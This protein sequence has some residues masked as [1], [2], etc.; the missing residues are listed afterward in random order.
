MTYFPN[1]NVIQSPLQCNDAKRRQLFADHGP[2]YWADKGLYVSYDLLHLPPGF[3]TLS[4]T[5]V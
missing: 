1:T 2:I 4:Y 5:L 3:K